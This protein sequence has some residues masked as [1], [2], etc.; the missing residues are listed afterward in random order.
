MEEIVDYRTLISLS[1][2]MVLLTWMAGA[3]GL[4]LPAASTYGQL[5]RLLL[6][7]LL[8]THLVECAVFFRTLRRTGRPLGLEL[9]QTL[10]FGVIHYA[11]AK[12][13]ASTAAG[14]PRGADEA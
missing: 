12:S 5:G 8:A 1:K 14:P 7:I 3:A 9:S 10:L 4:F 2:G 11:E 13:L 6:G